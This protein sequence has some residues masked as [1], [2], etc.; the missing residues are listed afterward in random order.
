MGLRAWDPS[1]TI[2]LL[3]KHAKVLAQSSSSSYE[4][5]LKVMTL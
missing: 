3:A 4:K 5:R 2:H 1:K